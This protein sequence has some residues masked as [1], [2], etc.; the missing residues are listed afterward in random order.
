MFRLVGTLG[1]SCSVTPWQNVAPMPVDLYG[2]AAASN[3]TYAYV[4]GGYSFSTGTTLNVLNR[5]DPVANAWTPMANMPD[6]LT[7]MASAVYYPPTNK[8]YVFGGE[9]AVSGVN[10]NATR[11]YDIAT[12]T[13]SAGANMPDV[14]SFM[15]C[16]L[17]SRQRQDLPRQR[18]QHRACHERPARHVGIRSG[19]KHFHFQGAVPTPRRWHG[20]RR[21]QWPPLRGR[22][23]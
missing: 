16:R 22:R 21:Y 4:A 3:G 14:R 10:T 20:L 5:F 7:L 17:Q 13:W 8:I 11:I 23:A 19:G 2:A 12:N 6:A 18:L 15:A 9:D 1:G